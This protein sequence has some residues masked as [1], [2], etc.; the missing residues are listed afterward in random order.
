MP[1]ARRSE[2]L[3]CDSLL[4]Q[5]NCRRTDAESVRANHAVRLHLFTLE[6]KQ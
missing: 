6:T 2:A 1:L 4:R 3:N 5:T